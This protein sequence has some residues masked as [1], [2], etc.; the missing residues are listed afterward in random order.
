M[1]KLLAIHY[2]W[3][4]IML[5]QQ[6]QNQ[7]QNRLQWKNAN[8]KMFRIANRNGIIQ[9]GAKSVQK[10]ISDVNFYTNFK[11]IKLI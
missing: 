4:Q 8:S 1:I 2:V 10:G 5:I 6:H 7:Q 9:N 11:L 3:T